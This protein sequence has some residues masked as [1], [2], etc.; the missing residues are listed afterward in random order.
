[1]KLRSLL[2]YTLASLLVVVIG[3][4]AVTAQQKQPVVVEV[5]LAPQASGEF[6]IQSSKTEFSTGVPYRFVV[7][8]AG[9]KKHEVG[10]WRQGEEDARAAVFAIEE[11]ELLP[12]SVATRNATFSKSGEFEFAC[13]FGNHY[14]KGMKLPII[15]K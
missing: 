15:V 10:I 1:M 9:R 7:R 8:N 4:T 3:H 11:D 14:E 6:T 2:I 13:H 5:T 12:N